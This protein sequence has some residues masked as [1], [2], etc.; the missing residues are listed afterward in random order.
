MWRKKEQIS[1]C[2]YNLYIL[3]AVTMITCICQQP[4][5]MTHMSY[6]KQD[7]NSS[8]GSPPKWSW[9]V[10]KHGPYASI[11]ES[12]PLLLH[13]RGYLHIS[14]QP[15]SLKKPHKIPSHINLPP[16][17]AMSG[18]V[19]KCMVI[20]VPPLSKC[21]HCYPPAS[22]F[23]FAILENFYKQLSLIEWLNFVKEEELVPVVPG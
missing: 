16:F 1:L 19:F 22:R 20:V 10:F 14:C 7:L 21:K 4:L 15:Y 23:G 11:C 13:L 6:S 2:V 5:P 12:H 9:V 17:Q 18:W 8:Y 3:E